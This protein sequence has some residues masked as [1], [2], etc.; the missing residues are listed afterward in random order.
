M[1]NRR[2]RVTPA[3]VGMAPGLRRRTPG[4]RREEVAQLSGVGVTWYTW[5]EQGR[6]IN[7]SPQVLDAVARTLRLDASEREH[8]Y[9]LAEVACVPGRQ[10]DVFEVGAEIQGII[11]ALDP[12]PAV[13][14][15]TRYDILAT[16]PAYR[17]LFAVPEIVGTGIRN[18]LW[19]LFTASED[20]CPV[21]HRSQELPIMV[22]TLRG[23]YGRHAGEP[24]WES[25]VERLSAASPYFAELW[26]SGNV[27]PPGPRVKTF[28]HWALPG[29]I[30]MT[31]V[32]LSVNGLPEC[33]IVAYTPADEESG[34][35]VAALRR[36]RER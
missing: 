14:Y 28:R 22:A 10:S 5:L 18:V 21:V 31:S 29:E 26:R 12:H 8:L 20:A 13:V 24:A 1:R 3:D 15:N 2:A 33:R 17:D 9:H 23:A 7:A 27:A 35:R 16:N 25:F 32:S 6:P 4:L 30:R 19:T 36:N 11:D 34:E